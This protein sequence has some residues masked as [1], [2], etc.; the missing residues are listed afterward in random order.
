[1]RHILFTNLQVAYKE[2]YTKNQGKMLGTDE[3]MEMTLSKELKPI[4]SKNAYKE[5]AK[6]LQTD[7]HHDIG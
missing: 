6:E 5:K 3:T 2:D 4:I 7:V 1:M